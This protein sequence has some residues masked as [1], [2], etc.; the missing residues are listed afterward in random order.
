MGMMDNL[1][2][3]VDA[4]V[5]HKFALM[6]AAV[7]NGALADGVVPSL[8]T[9]F[10]VDP[11]ADLDG[12]YSTGNGS[13]LDLAY[14]VRRAPRWLAL[15]LPL[16]GID[17]GGASVF[18]VV[19]KSSAPRAVT[20]RVALRSAVHGGAVDAFLPKHVVAYAEE[21]THA[22]ILKVPG[23]EDVPPSAEWRD[24]ILFFSP[25]TSALTLRD[26]RVFIV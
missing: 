15:H 8:G 3:G 26:F 7:G 5:N 2:F 6:R 21:S 22:D 12:S 10:S 24:L 1:Q 17:L 20:F 14:T 16:G 11:E 19:C 25:E 4:E 23:R 13:V 18:G 9:F